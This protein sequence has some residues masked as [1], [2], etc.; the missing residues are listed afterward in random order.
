MGSACRLQFAGLGVQCF[1]I[2]SWACRFG[3]RF[4][5]ENACRPLKELVFPLF[6]LVGTHVKLLGQFH[7]RLLAS[8]GG[9]RYFCLESR[10]MVPGAVVSSW[11]LLFPAFKPKSG[12]NSTYPRC[13]D[14]PSQLS[15][16]SDSNCSP[17]T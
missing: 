7:Q 2:D 3:L 1:D 17:G 11:S 10:A 5:T 16:A 4:I 8:D 15:S 9:Q 12:R 13:P 14:F 6:D